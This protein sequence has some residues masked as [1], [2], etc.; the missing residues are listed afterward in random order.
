MSENLTGAL[1]PLGLKAP[2]DLNER[3]RVRDATGKLTWKHVL[4][5]MVQRYEQH[6]SLY[7]S[8]SVSELGFN[9]EEVVT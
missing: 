3:T 5:P 4:N 8:F 7:H 9:L 2:F 1:E 6:R